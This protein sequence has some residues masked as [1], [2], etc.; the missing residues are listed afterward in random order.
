LGLS[1]GAFLPFQ[2][3]DKLAAMQS[4]AD[5]SLVTM[6]RDIGEV[7]VPSKVL[8]YFAAG[9]PV[10]AAVP[11]DSETARMIRRA[12]AGTVVPPDDGPALAAALL[13]A[14]RNRAGMRRFGESARDFAVQNLSVQAAVRRYDAVFRNICG[15]T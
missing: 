9:R 3:E 15:T 2:P 4:C 12:G 10:I 14:Y 7:S 1:N 13:E 6:K 8:A 5:V 11:E